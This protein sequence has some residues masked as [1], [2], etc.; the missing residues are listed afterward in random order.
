MTPALFQEPFPMF[1]C[2]E[3]KITVLPWQVGS[4][5]F[6]KPDLPHYFNRIRQV[7]TTA[8]ERAT[9]TLRR[10]PITLVLKLHVKS[11]QRN[12]IAIK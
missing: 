7:A 11:L 1:T 5:L 2:G 3:A 8:Q 9:N 4:N 6:Y 12:I 10:V